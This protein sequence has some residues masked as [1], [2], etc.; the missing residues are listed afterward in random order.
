LFAR[1]TRLLFIAAGSA[2]GRGRDPA[3]GGLAGIGP[4]ACGRSTPPWRQGVEKI[5]RV[6]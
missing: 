6:A 4:R 2:A 1:L 5:G 3:H